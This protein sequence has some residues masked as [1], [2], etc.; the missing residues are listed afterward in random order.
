MIYSNQLCEISNNKIFGLQSFARFNEEYELLQKRFIERAIRT[1]QFDYEGYNVDRLEEIVEEYLGDTFAVCTQS[2]SSAILLSLIMSNVKYGDYVICPSV[3]SP[4][5]L[6][7]IFSIGAIPIFV[8][9]DFK[10]QTLDPYLLEYSITCCCMGTL[11]QYCSLPPEVP[12]LKK[13][14]KAIITYHP[15]GI[16]TNM[17]EVLNVG[18]KYGIKVIENAESAFGSYR[19]EKF[20][21][22]WGDFGVFS[23][24]KGE[25]VNV[26]SGGILLC[27]TFDSKQEV[28]SLLSST[29]ENFPSRRKGFSSL[30]TGMNNLTAGIALAQVSLIDELIEQKRAISAYYE[31]NLLNNLNVSWFKEEEGMFFNKNYSWFEPLMEKDFETLSKQIEFSLKLE[32]FNVPSVYCSIQDKEILKFSPYIGENPSLDFGK[33]LHL[34]TNSYL[35]VEQL[36][37]VSDIFR[38]YLQT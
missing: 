2:S 7:A 35:E 12:F 36:K 28:K 14:P 19:N 1:Q 26:G 4:S 5:S 10:S 15:D 17:V 16:A 25:L 24:G 6:D 33:R 8:G 3:I 9:L 23:F 38:Y 20:C 31:E 29:F 22:T 32:G 21:G 37:S 34:P 27:P 13:M 30:I 18:R 11:N